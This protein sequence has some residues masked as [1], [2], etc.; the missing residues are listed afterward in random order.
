MIRVDHCDLLIPDVYSNDLIKKQA[1]L[2]TVEEQQ[3][4]PRAKSA[5]SN[6]PIDFT[7][8]RGLSAGYGNPDRISSGTK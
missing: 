2:R 1:L 8:R 6:I 5:A 3:Q 4:Q 7:K